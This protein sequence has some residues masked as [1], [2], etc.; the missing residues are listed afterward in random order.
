MKYKYACF[1]HPK[2]DDYEEKA[3]SDLCPTC[4]NPLGFPVDPEIAPQKIR[5][6]NILQPLERGYYGA[7]YVAEIETRI[8]KKRVVLKIIPKAIYELFNKDFYQE[9][10]THDEASNGAEHIVNIED[11]FE[12][13]IQF[14]NGEKILCYV[15]ILDYIEGQTLKSYLHSNSSIPIQTIA[16]IAI[17]CLK[18]LEDLR[19]KSISHNDLHMGNL[20]VSPLSKS[21]FRPYEID[22]STKLYAIDFG[23]SSEKTQS[24]PNKKR[25]G[26]LHW[27]ASI[28]EILSKKILD[29]PT[30][31]EERDFR[32]AL[33]LEERAKII[34]PSVSNQRVYSFEELITQI[35]QIFTQVTSPWKTPLQLRS[36]NDS[37]NAQTLSPWFVPSLIVDDEDKWIS[38][39]SSKGPQVITGMRGCGKT[40]L[41]RAL[42]FHARATPQ[43]EQEKLDSK[44]LLERLK[45]DSYIGIYLS[46]TRLLD[47]LGA[48]EH[49][50]NSPFERLFIAYSIEILN[51]V[52]HLRELASEKIH[53]DAFQKIADVITSNINYSSNLTLKGSEY[54]IEKSLMQILNSLSK[55]EESY[56]ITS[57]PAIA[58]NELATAIRTLTYEWSNSYILFLLDDVSTRFLNDQ[59]IIRLVSA[60][61]FQSEICAFKFTTE[62]QTLEMVINSPGNIEQA[63][64]G[65]DYQIFDLG[66]EVNNKIHSNKSEGIGFVESILHKRSLYHSNHPNKIMPKEFLGN[67][68][69]QNIAISITKEGKAS[70]KKGIY[71]GITA[72]AGVCVGD[73]GDV[74]NLYE[75]ILKTRKINNKLPI[76]PTIQNEAYLELCNSRLF[77]INRR[78]TKLFDFAES[79]AEAAHHLLVQSYKKNKHQKSPRLRQYSSIFINISSGDIEKQNKQIRELIDAGIFNFSG[80]PEASRTNRQGLNPQQQ[81]KLTFRKIHGLN[82]HIGLSQ[83]DRFELSGE[84]LEE[85]LNNPKKGKEILIRNLA[86][87]AV[88]SESDG[89]NDEE[90]NIQPNIGHQTNMFDIFNNIPRNLEEPPKIHNSILLEKVPKINVEDLSYESIKTISNYITSFGFEDATLESLKN[91]LS[92]LPISSTFL[93]FKEAGKTTHIKEFLDGNELSYTTINY[94]SLKV[95]NFRIQKNT[96]IDITGIPQSLIFELVRKSIKN[97]NSLSVAFTKAKTYYPLNKD[98]NIVLKQNKDSSDKTEVL[99]SIT[100][101]LKGETGPYKISPLLPVETNHSSRR[102]L[103]AFATSKHERL[104]SLLDEREFDKI[105]IITPKGKS[106]RHKLARI[107]ADIALTRFNNAET[108][109]IDDYSV[110]DITEF[111]TAQYQTYFI[112]QNF[113]FEIALSGNK[114]QAL[115]SALICDSLVINQCWYIQPT[116]WD[117]KRFTKGANKTEIYK[118]NKNGA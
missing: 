62:A 23:S 41:L 56:N 65:R 105:I 31:T 36:F 86:K 94:P 72:I 22:Q 4:K 18:I 61:L 75:K 91:I 106:A 6:Y 33:L 80:G 3:L 84:A 68:T 50:L 30:G 19:I 15:A 107:S 67:E 77:D 54:E 87:D 32:L 44:L 81:Y 111:I 71:H 102:I 64:I 12:E 92:I 76:S 34:F 7:T 95:K 29:S 115:A 45:N 8:K 20:I 108:H 46:C 53:P 47:S 117:T 39:I 78:D 82:K 57:N 98:I 89:L 74:I 48:H 101:I 1:L 27:V 11:A 83:S 60:L 97:N 49:P 104:Y 43:N 66:Q 10:K 103:I 85:W 63:R 114:I 51:A 37:Y 116:I 16:Q 90:N 9:C 109:E 100:K 28:L 73:I 118:I 5:A 99:K 110:N 113:S 35:R 38:E 70:T 13:L 21:N 24:D 55:G 26:D 25:L 79:F 93:K 14:Q 17:D 112:N 69:L 52:R 58:F 96:L 42:Q 40:M 88:Y 59:N 2:I